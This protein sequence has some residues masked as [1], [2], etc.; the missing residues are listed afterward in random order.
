MDFRKPFKNSGQVRGKLL[1]KSAKN[2]GHLMGL[3]K[4]TV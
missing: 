1:I 3:T 2:A 4:H